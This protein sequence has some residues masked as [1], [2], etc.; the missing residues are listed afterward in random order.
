MEV[1]I[2]KLWII[3]IQ[4]SENRMYFKKKNGS[5]EGVECTLA[6]GDLLFSFHAMS[7]Q[8]INQNIA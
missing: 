4:L 3:S 2:I 6:G 1:F 7:K 5:I 8:Q